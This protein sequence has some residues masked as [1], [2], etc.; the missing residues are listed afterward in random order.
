M[1][2]LRDVTVSAGARVLARCAALEARPGEA[3]VIVG[4]TGSG[5]SLLAAAMIGTLPAEL[6]LSGSVRFDGAEVAGDGAKLRALWGR[7]M[8]LVPQ[9]PW[10]AL[11]PTMSAFGQVEEVHRLVRR[12]GREESRRRTADSLA[13]FGLD[14]GERRHPFALSG[15]MCQRVAL[16]IAHAADA[17]LIVADEPTKGLDAALRDEVVALLRQERDRGAALVVITHDLAVA[18]GLGGRIAVMLESEIVEQ[19][20]TATVLAAPRH[21]YTRRMVEADPERWAPLPIS[22]LG[23]VVLG[24]RGL[25]KRF[26]ARQLFAGLDATFR[27]GESVAILGPSGSGKT[28]VGNVLLGLVR[29]DAGSIARG[30]GLPALRYQKLYQDPAAAFAAGQSLRGALDD[31]ARLHRRDWREVERLMERLRLAADLLDRRPDQI[32]GGELQRFALARTLLVDPVFLFA[33]EPTSRLDPITQKDV[34]LLLAEITAERGMAMLLVTHDP[35][36]ADRAAT[37]RLALSA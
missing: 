37:R 16:A 31:V 7:R 23:D 3:L 28:T 5:K 4:E 14:R 15:G 26:G 13:S 8:A 22:P 29:A 21:A 30:A 10:L 35:G 33:D 9:E 11:D 32:S 19:G 27:R 1:M 24:A 20:D 6:D 18:R 25:A 17:D 12:R 36:L 34:M 2:E